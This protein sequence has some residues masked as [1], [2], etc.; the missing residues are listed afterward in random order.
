MLNR[1]ITNS[2]L[3]QRDL[4]LVVNCVSLIGF[5]AISGEIVK[6]HCRRESQALLAIVGPPGFTYSFSNSLISLDQTITS[7]LYYTKCLHVKMLTNV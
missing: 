3:L 5:Q 1:Y 4:V 6:I 7:N 2:D